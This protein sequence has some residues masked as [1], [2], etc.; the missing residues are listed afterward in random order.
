VRDA[1]WEIADRDMVNALRHV[2]RIATP[3]ARYVMQGR[4]GASYDLWSRD[5]AAYLDY[6]RPRQAAAGALLAAAC[7]VLLAWKRTRRAGA[8]LVT[9]ALAWSAWSLLAT[10]PRELPPPP[11]QFATVTAI[12]LLSAGAAVAA[13]AFLTQGRAPGGPAKALG[14]G[15]AAV[16]IAAVLAFFACGATRWYGVFPVGG[17]GWE[18]IFDPVGSA[19]VA[20]A[21]ATAL[22]FLD[23]VLYRRLFA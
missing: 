8:A 2:D 15:S 19:L 18:L 10:Q 17:E 11:L 23:R 12:A 9:A 5:R 16:G 14:Q 20:G 3:G 13:V 7:G 22:S 21:A 1:L 4:Y 6:R